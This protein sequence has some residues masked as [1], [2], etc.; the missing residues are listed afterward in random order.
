MVRLQDYRDL[1]E[2]E[3]FDKIVSV[4]MYEHVGRANM[5][6]YFEKLRRALK[7]DG[8]VLNHGITTTNPDGRSNGPIGGTFI[9]RFVFPGGE[10][11]HLSQVVNQIGR[12]GFDVLDVESL[13]PHY[14][15]TLAL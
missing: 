14:A 3:A 15:T 7:T 4:G 12:H 5:G 10:L 13:R 6:T 1:E 2:S 8:L 9:D 11:P